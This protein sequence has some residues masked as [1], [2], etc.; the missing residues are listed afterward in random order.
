MDVNL[1]IVAWF[2]DK[3]KTGGDW[4]YKRFGSAYEAFGNYNYGAVGAAIGY[5]SGILLRA[6][7]AVQNWTDFRRVVQGRSR[8]GSGFFLGGSPYGDDPEDQAVISK[9]IDYAYERH[10]RS[11]P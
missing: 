2:A 10:H 9:G 5:T 3:V 8:I 6:A 11:C 4:D 7:G 1:L